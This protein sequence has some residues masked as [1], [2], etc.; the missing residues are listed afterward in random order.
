MGKYILQVRVGNNIGAVQAE[1]C[2]LE[3]AMQNSKQRGLT[4]KQ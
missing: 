1:Q 4:T 3:Q 2:E